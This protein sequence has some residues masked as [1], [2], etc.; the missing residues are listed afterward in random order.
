MVKLWQ[1]SLAVTEE[2]LYRPFIRLLSHFGEVKSYPRIGEYLENM[3]CSGIIR[4][5]T[6]EVEE[7]VRGEDSEEEEE[8]QVKEVRF[9]RKGSQFMDMWREIENNLVLAGLND[10]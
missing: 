7:Q 5:G 1:T 8:I 6:M 2:D 9:L 10:L 4:W 3:E